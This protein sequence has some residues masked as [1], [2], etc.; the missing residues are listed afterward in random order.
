MS[1]NIF[2]IVFS[3]TVLVEQVYYIDVFISIYIHKANKIYKIIS[4][5][6]DFLLFIYYYKY[7]SSEGEI[8]FEVISW[9][10]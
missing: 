1:K 5:K 2:F 3:L 10:R 6:F 8:T 7:C 4:P 9:I